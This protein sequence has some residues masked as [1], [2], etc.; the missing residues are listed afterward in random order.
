MSFPLIYVFI[1]FIIYLAALVLA[2]A[3]GVLNLCCGMWDLSLW[4][5]NTECGLWDLVP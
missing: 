2:A 3:L 1:I 5:V 4:Q